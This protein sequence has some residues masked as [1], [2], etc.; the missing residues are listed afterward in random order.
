MVGQPELVARGVRV[1]GDPSS[2]AF[3]LTA[4]L[5]VPGSTLTVKNVGLNPR[6]V[7]LLTTLGEMGAEISIANRREE[8]GEPVGDVSVRHGPL[9]GVEVPASRA[10][11]MID[12]YPILAVAAS[13]ARGRTAMRGL[14]ELRVK[15]SDRLAA[16]AR[17]LAS[18]R[19]GPN[20]DQRRRRSD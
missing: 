2:A 19:Q 8:G 18:I 20:I 9:T 14:A 17:G 3:P 12:E 10:P 7:G 15:E 11:S 4:A 16:I 13:F 6:R 1:P 5:V